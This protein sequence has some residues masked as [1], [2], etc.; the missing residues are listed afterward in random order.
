MIF[1]STLSF[2]ALRLGSCFMRSYK[3][4]QG[5]GRLLRS[6]VS[7]EKCCDGHYRRAWSADMPFPDRS[8]HSASSAPNQI[9]TQKDFLVESRPKED[10]PGHSC[11]PCGSKWT[12]ILFNNLIIIILIIYTN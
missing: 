6:G 10:T 12:K 5:C 8:L 7:R 4:S 11:Q 3:N 9:W 2:V 1:K